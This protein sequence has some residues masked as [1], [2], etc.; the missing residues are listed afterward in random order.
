MDPAQHD[1]RPVVRLGHSPDP[2]DVFMWWPLFEPAVIASNRFRF[3]PVLIDIEAANRRAE[4]GDDLLEITALSCGQYP[5]VADTYVM[6]AC[7]SSIGE[8]YGPK[9]VAAKPLSVQSLKSG[10][11][12]I[13]IPGHR[14][15]AALVTNLL[16]GPGTFETLEVPFK[17]VGACVMRGEADAGVVIHE[18]QLTFEE[19][20]LVLV[21]DLGRWW[22]ERTKLPLPLGLNVVRR[23]LED[24]YG[25]GSL[26]EIARMLEASVDHARA[27]PEEALARA[28][29]HAGGMAPSLTRAFVELYVNRMTVDVGERGLRAVERLLDEAAAEGLVPSIEHSAPLRSGVGG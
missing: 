6:T 20:G 26:A 4:S 5:R 13:A 12:T 1:D 19:D 3:E 16:L 8:G 29:E 23:D 22:M 21:E 7:G 11:P 17:D 27:H 14:T 24:L 2:D 28:Q 10:T 15:T 25:P 18:G 9:L